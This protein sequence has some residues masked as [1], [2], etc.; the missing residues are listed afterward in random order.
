MNLIN[1]FLNDRNKKIKQPTKKAALF[2]INTSATATVK[3]LYQ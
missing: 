1:I 2:K 3:S